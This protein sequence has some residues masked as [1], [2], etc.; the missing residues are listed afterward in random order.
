MKKI[1]KIVRL[2]IFFKIIISC[3][4]PQIFYK[5]E[6]LTYNKINYGFKVKYFH[7]DKKIG[8]IAY[9]DEGDGKKTL[10]FIHGIGAY[11]KYF[12]Y[13]IQELKKNYRIIALDMP[14]YGKSTFDINTKYSIKLH[15]Q[16]LEMFII[17]MNLKNLTLIGH[18]YGSIIAAELSIDSDLNIKKTIMLTAQAFNYLVEKIMPG[19]IAI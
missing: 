7:I 10:L 16:I 1:Y 5:K 2:I 13:Q 15:K 6:K 14:G 11:S 18:S 3:S 12:Y 17:K 4:N 8:K 9:V 19:L